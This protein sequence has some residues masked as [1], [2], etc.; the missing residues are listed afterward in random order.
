[1]IRILR[2]VSFT[3]KINKSSELLLRAFCIKL[4]F[5]AVFKR[6]DAHIFLKQA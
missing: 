1:L 4:L 3:D 2:D 6:G 5:S